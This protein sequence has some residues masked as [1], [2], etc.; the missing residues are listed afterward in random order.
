MLRDRTSSIPASL[1]SLLFRESAVVGGGWECTYDFFQLRSRLGE[2]VFDA[3]RDLA[4]RVA[5]SFDVRRDAEAVLG[6]DLL[7][8]M[9]AVRPQR[10]GDLLTVK[11]S[12]GTGPL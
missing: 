10:L 11:Y 12:F 7:D 4:P 1:L 6:Y 9:S 8:R 3:R 2:F 5:I